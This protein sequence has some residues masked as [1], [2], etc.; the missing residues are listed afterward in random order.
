MLLQWMTSKLGHDLRNR[1]YLAPRTAHIFRGV[2]GKLLEV[3]D[4]SRTQFNPE[5]TTYSARVQ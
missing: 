5:N 4:I 1:L 2:T 3:V